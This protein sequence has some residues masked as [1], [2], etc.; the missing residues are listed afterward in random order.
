MIRTV[1]DLL[2]AL[3][4]TERGK[5][6][7]YSSVGHPGIIGDMYEGLARTIT[8]RALLP[9]ANLRIVRGKV[10]NSKGELSR[11]IDCM[12]VDGDGERIPYT[13]HW[14]YDVRQVLAILE[15]KK[16]L[17]QGDLSDGIDLFVDFWRRI[18][19]PSAM[20]LNLLRDA[21]RAIHGTELP[22][23]EG[24][25]H[26]SIAEQ[27]LFHCLVVEAN[28]PVRVILGF[29]GYKSEASLRDG[30]TDLLNARMAGAG[31]SGVP[32]GPIPLPSLIVGPGGALLKLS[33]M[34]YPGPFG[35][36]RRWGFYGSR[37]A[38]PLTV[39]LELIWTRLNYYYDAPPSIFG[40]DLEVD[41]VNLLFE[42]RAEERGWEVNI[43]PATQ[44]ELDAHAGSTP[45]Q[46]P[47]LSKAAFTVVT[48]LCNGEE[49]SVTDPEF[50]AFLAGEKLSVAGLV[51]ELVSARL[52]S[53]DGSRIRLLTDQ[54]TAGIDPELGFVAAENKSGRFTRW[55]LK[56]IAERNKDQS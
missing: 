43:I 51:N 48:L 26:L 28:L 24:L 46:P 30:I 3:V 52:A 27:M 53:S 50:L 41:A 13:D 23:K 10:R 17:Y 19:E 35:K 39:L 1:G 40:E 31:A 9:V 49:V 7:E 44:H 54:C 12:I 5:L 25:Q 47:A 45:W 20:P 37:S 14:L 16:T 33:G 4:N 18:A 34:P 6:A 56:R 29:E 38:N 21:W 8:E 11:Q 15:V 32:L 36:D 55:M 42:G 2:K 22:S